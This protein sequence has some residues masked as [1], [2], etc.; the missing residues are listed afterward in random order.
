MPKHSLHFAAFDCFA[1]TILLVSAVTPPLYTHTQPMRAH[2]QCV[3]ADWLSLLTQITLVMCTIV[4]IRC[5]SDRRLFM[6]P[7]YLPSMLESLEACSGELV[8]DD[9]VL[10]DVI[11]VGLF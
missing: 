4:Y 5:W 9:K 3:T 10:F 8:G 7:L 11:I 2:H 1:S 6:A